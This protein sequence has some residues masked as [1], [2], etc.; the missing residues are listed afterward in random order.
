MDAPERLREN[1]RNQPIVRIVGGCVGFV[2]I[3]KGVDRCDRT[4]DLLAKDT[5]TPLHPSNHRRSVEV[6]VIAYATAT[7]ENLC[8]RG[9]RIR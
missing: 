9:G 3:I 4:E 1:I 7:G 8:S 2:I 6:T 5:R